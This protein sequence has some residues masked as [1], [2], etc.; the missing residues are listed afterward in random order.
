M[1]SPDD[2]SKSLYYYYYYYYHYHQYF[3]ITLIPGLQSSVLSVLPLPFSLS[4]VFGKPSINTPTRQ[5][6]TIIDTFCPFG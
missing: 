5:Q 4:S 6:A 2:T 3:F 1:T